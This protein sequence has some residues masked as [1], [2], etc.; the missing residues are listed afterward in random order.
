MIEYTVLK[1]ADDPDTLCQRLNDLGTQGYQIRSGSVQQ[2]VDGKL[3]GTLILQRVKASGG[4][5]S[6]Q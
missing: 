2:S 5:D 6:G 1:V 4:K 3:Y